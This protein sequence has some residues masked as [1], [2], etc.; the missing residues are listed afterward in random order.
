[1]SSEGL[2]NKHAA[3][4]EKPPP[5]PFLRAGDAARAAAARY[6]HQARFTAEVISGLEEFA[7]DGLE[8]LD[9]KVRGALNPCLNNAERKLLGKAVT[10]RNGIIHANYA[11]I[12]NTLKHAGYPVDAGQ[13]LK[14][15]NLPE[16]PKP[17]ELLKTLMEAVQTGKGVR[18]FDPSTPVHGNRFGHQLQASIDG[19]WAAAEKMMN[20]CCDLLR[21][22]HEKFIRRQQEP[23]T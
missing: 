19:T 14:L 5:D 16:N 20:D 13:R 22:A 8:E 3:M 23:P 6:E 2:C 15:V 18:D 7:S 12:R 11:Q 17:G 1:M 10:L 21:R 4:I 9:P